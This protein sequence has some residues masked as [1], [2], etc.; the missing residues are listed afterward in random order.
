MLIIYPAHHPV[1]LFFMCDLKFA[2]VYEHPE[3]KK[4]IYDDSM[5]DSVYRVVKQ[6]KE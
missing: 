5:Y 6:V 1:L 4:R 3:K 2:D